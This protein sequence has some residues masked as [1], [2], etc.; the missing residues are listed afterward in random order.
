VTLLAHRWLIGGHF[1]AG[2]SCVIPQTL[3]PD[4]VHGA[5]ITSVLFTNEGDII[6]H[7]TGSYASLTACAKILIDCHAPLSLQ[8]HFRIIRKS[9]QF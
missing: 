7:G 2:E 9:R 6:F 5:T 8:L 1:G 4:P 3:N